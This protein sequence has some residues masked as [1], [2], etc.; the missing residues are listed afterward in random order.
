[1]KKS[2]EMMLRGCGKI[3]TARSGGLLVYSGVVVISS[4][5]RWFWGGFLGLDVYPIGVGRIPCRG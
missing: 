2:A 1:M 4:G 3:A 5:F